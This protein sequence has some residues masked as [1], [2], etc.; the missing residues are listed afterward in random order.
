[1]LES[2]EKLRVAVIGIGSMGANHA[3]I[4][5]NREDVQLV[6]LV[7]LNVDLTERV[8]R[9]F[10][11]EA[12]PSVEA[13]LERVKPEV[14]SIAVPTVKHREVAE[15]CLRGGVHCLLEKPICA[16]VEEG[17]ALMALA[18]ETRRVLLPGHI[19]RYNPAVQALAE[20]IRKGAIGSMY[21][22][23]IE[24]SGPFPP[25]IRDTGVSLDLAVHDLDIVSM[26]V[27]TLPLTLY[28][29]T[30]RLLHRNYE[31][32][33]V[34]ILRYPKDVVAI[35]NINW[36][37]PTKRRILKVFGSR[38]MFRVDYLDQELRFFENADQV[39]SDFPWENP[40]IREGREIRYAIG[41]KEPLAVEVD[42]LLKCVRKGIN[43]ESEIR[44][45]INALRLAT[46]LVRAGSE[47]KRVDLID[48]AARFS[49]DLQGSGLVRT[50]FSAA[51][52]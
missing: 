41:N 11:T 25:R 35:L 39:S 9:R 27:G 30:Q 38:G 3:R 7:D 22:I 43:T 13:L 2:N 49:A 33:V 50:A 14:V 21:R 44:D 46:M 5:A 15:Q 26:L 42:Y 24:R 1:M 52:Q 29:E 34:A 16:S 19:E 31:D 48:V 47:N 4:Y 20:H 40:G 12:F 8:A 37:S 23:E 32:S 28:S 17:E 36:T 10:S 51:G 45:S 6:G 18:T